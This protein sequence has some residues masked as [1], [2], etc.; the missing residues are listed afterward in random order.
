MGI[1]GLRLPQAGCRAWIRKARSKT[2]LR[3]LCPK[4]VLLQAGP[5]AVLP[6]QARAEARVCAQTELQAGAKGV[7]QVRAKGELQIGASAETNQGCQ[8]GLLRRWKFS[9]I[10]RLWRIQGLKSYPLHLLL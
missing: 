1:G 2:E 6:E 4:K 3:P 5:Q 9:R 7:L 8:A 10:R